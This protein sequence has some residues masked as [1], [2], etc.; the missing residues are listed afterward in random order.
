MGFTRCGIYHP[1]KG[2]RAIFLSSGSFLMI[3]NHFGDFS[4]I[5]IFDPFVTPKWPFLTLK[6]WFSPNWQ[7]L[8]ECSVFH[9]N[10]GPKAIFLSPGSFLVILNHFGD[11]WKIA[12]STL[13]LNPKWPFL[14]VNPNFL[15]TRVEPRHMSYIIRI[16]LKMRNFYVRGRIW[17]FLSI[18]EIFQKSRFLTPLWPQNGHFWP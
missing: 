18:L 7:G 11:F 14:T 3:L 4:K 9:Q 13:F 6:P 2:L 8:K 5:A 1:N 10:K 15:E 12:I 16:P 17:W